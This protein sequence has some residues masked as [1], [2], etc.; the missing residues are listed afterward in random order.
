MGNG[1][2]RQSSAQIVTGEV[3][4]AS[5]LNAEF[6]T[7]QSAFNGTTGHTHDGSVGEG[8]LINLNN[9]IVGILPVLNGGIGGLNNPTATS[10]PGVTDDSDDGYNTGS[11]WVNTTSDTVFI[12]VDDSVGAAI[13]VTNQLNDAGLTSI[14]GLTT[15]ADQMIYTTAS[16]VYAT[17]ALTPFA[18]T[19]L[20]DTTA[21][22]VL[23][24]LGVSTYA[25]TLLDDADAATARTTLG[26]GTISTQA[27]SS[28]AI[29]GG[30]ISGATITGGSIS[31]TTITGGS[32]SGMTD[33]AIADGGTGASDIT[34]AKTNF[35]LENVDNT[36]DANKP[37]STATQTA[38]D[39]KANTADVALKASANTFTNTN[40][41]SGI[42]A[43]NGAIGINNVSTYTSIQRLSK[44]A[45]V[46]S[47]TT[48]TLGTDGNYFDV[49]GT[50][51][52]TGIATVRVGSVIKLHF[53]ASLVLTHNASTLNLPGGVDIT[54]T[55]G[56]EAEFIERGVGQWACINYR[57]ADGLPVVQPM[58]TAK[59][60]STDQTI[61]SA[62][63]LTLA[64]SLGAAPTLVQVQ[65]KCA[66]AEHGYSVGDV[67]PID[68]SDN[69][70][71]TNTGVSI[72]MGATNLDVRY[73]SSANVFFGL[74]KT[75]GARATFTNSSWR[76][77]ARAWL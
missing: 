70:N 21:S 53:D 62:G 2:V 47:A 9:S 8:P 74:H 10:D 27:A 37:V 61:T 43:L 49:T 73:G 55:A 39:L 22:D 29:T 68:F 76:L 24:T 14:A 54:T 42:T 48:L 35:E 56:D 75:T 26:L 44:G 16:D 77:V 25:K 71:S 15:S 52:I 51:T 66:S 59:F 33:I 50:T 7:L 18:R 30:T 5:P 72:V 45:D 28:V 31:G 23:T 34:G 41:F 65:L 3:V 6:N 1:Y 63:S 32:I 19:V 40:T 38:L 17:T 67:I 20:D 11:I 60:A 4:E 58:F 69:V 13:W 12:C 64:H 36:S 46:A 57:R